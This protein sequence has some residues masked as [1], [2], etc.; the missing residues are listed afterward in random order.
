M[1]QALQWRCIGPHR[2][3]RVVAVAGDP[4]DPRTF[5]F[6]GCA[7]GV[8]K[9]TDGGA[10]WANISD[11]FFT[12]AAVGAIA[13]A[14]SDPNVLYAGTGEA[15]IRGNVS[16]GDGVYRSTDAGR[17]WMHMG[18]ADTRHIARIRVHPKDP[19]V[20][21]VAALGHAF[22]P[23]QERGVFR[24]TDGG[25]NWA[26]VLFRSEDS[27]AIDLSLDPNNSR[28]LYAAI[29][30]ARRT[31]WSLS[32]GG[33]E[34]GIWKSSDGGDTWAELTQNEGLPRGVKGRIGIAVSPAKAG[35]VYAVIEAADGAIFR[36]DDGGS[37][38]Q[39]LS[40][41]GDLRRRA[42]YY[43]HIFADPQDADT[44]WVLNLQ[45]WKSIDA[46][47]SFTDVPTPHGDN[48][49]LWIDPRNPERMIE[50]NDGGACVSFNGG[51]SWS[52]IYNQPTAQFYHVCTDGQAPYR[53]FGSQQ[54]NSAI[55]VPSFSHLGAITAS[56]WFVPG[57]GESG[58]IAV[59]PGDPNIIVGGAVGSGAGDGRMTQ[60]DRRTGQIRNITIWPE[61]SGAG[62]GA[63]DLKYRFQWTFPIHYSRWDPEVLYVGGNRLFRSTD[64]GASF[65]PISGDLTRNDPSRLGASGGPI[66]KD[67]TGAEYYGTIFAFAESP[68]ERGVCWA[69]SDDG[70][71]HR[72]ADGGRTWDD[73]TPP[74]LPEWS[75]ISII[76]P[77]PHA[78]A[79]VYVAAHC[80]RL[81][82]YQPYLLKTND[83]G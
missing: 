75:T 15:C 65:E 71:I 3:G 79:T 48:H 30:Q 14:P 17:T 53:V 60:Y 21:Y 36:S 76:E 16:H 45:C 22:G 63:G 66:T 52:S 58:Y 69:G 74:S 23:N 28:V 41:Q 67:N 40:E 13:V 24:S 37:T 64:D 7:G 57:G 8:W 83:S 72:S 25:T 18:L 26:K 78:P 42:W 20:V 4:V 81:D 35:R 12:T 33:P 82:D 51:A 27:G 39:R 73:V 68:H 5:Y 46:G 77:S 32:S 43:D 50:G 1:L 80:Y 34:S 62:V 70:L 59:K 11:G 55:S 61:I 9:S 54:D 56:E 29:W 6:G 31:P 38:W 47:A 49:D 2:G 10:S 19:D 44:V